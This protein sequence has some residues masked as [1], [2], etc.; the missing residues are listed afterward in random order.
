MIRPGPE[1]A[2]CASVFRLAVPDQVGRGRAGEHL[3]RGTGSSLEF[4][5]RRAYAVGDDVRH[6]DWRA[7]GRTDQLQ[8]RVYQEEIQPRVEILLDLSRSMSVEL[9]KL[10]MATDLFAFIGRISVASG[11][12]TKLI[13]VGDAVQPVE[14]LQLERDGVE[15]EGRRPLREGIDRAL[16]MLHPGSFRF[17]ISDVLSPVDPAHLV[18][19]LAARAGRFVLLQILAASDVN[20]PAGEALRLEDSESGEQ[21]DLVLDEPTVRQYKEKLARLGGELTAE[22][23][24]ARGQHVEL[25]AGPA[26]ERVC[27]EWFIPAGL[28]TIA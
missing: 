10:Q 16:P 15:F 4:Q 13:L 28:L 7:F 17:L 2:R 27:R 6:L 3:A 26:L 1:V 8:V 11:F 21:L 9:L 5:D 14:L 18:R 24:R 19:S 12:H 22:C 25:V 20:P 23:Q